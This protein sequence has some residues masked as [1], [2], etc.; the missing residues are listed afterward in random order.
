MFKVAFKAFKLACEAFNLAFEAFNCLINLSVIFESVFTIGEALDVPVKVIADDVHV[1]YVD[2][3]VFSCFRFS[4]MMI[5]KGTGY[6]F[7]LIQ[8]TKLPLEFFKN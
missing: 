5:S 3:P 7:F 6:L 2:V 1:L 4:L 8:V